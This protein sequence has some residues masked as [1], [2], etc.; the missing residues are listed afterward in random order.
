MKGPVHF[1]IGSRLFS[2]SHDTIRCDDIFL[3]RK[4]HMAQVEGIWKDSEFIA[5]EFDGD[6]LVTGQDFQIPD[7]FLV[8]QDNDIAFCR[9]F[10]RHDFSQKLHTLTGCLGILQNHTGH[11]GL[12]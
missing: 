7:A 1:L 11:G 8:G 4:I 12:R 9:A 3:I 10:F 6:I 2:Q 5:W